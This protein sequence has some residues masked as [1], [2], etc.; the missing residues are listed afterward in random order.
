[1][2]WSCKTGWRDAGMTGCA[3]RRLCSSSMANIACGKRGRLCSRR[4]ANIAC[5]KRGRLCSRRTANIASA[6]RGR[7]CSR[8]VMNVR[9]PPSSPPPLQPTLH[10]AGEAGGAVRR[11]RRHGPH[12]CTRAPP[13]SPPF[14][15]GLCI[16]H[17]LCISHFRPFHTT[18][19]L[20][21][22]LQARLAEL[23]A[24][25]GDTGSALVTFERVSQGYA[26]TLGRSHSEAQVGSQ[27][28]GMPVWPSGGFDV[29]VHL[30]TRSSGG[31]ARRI[32]G[33]PWPGVAEA[34]RFGLRLPQ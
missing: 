18:P 3:R 13:E 24:A 2:R 30:P 4:T 22:V 32:L 26:K 23:Y 31:T 12:T 11:A 29:C 9:P 14:A 16:S 21:R 33:W 5:A 1:M 10:V 28:G 27:S 19:P 20:H 25:H 7:L 8:I 6:K 17:R 15:L 34:G